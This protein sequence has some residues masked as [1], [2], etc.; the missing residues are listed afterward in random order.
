MKIEHLIAKNGSQTLKINDR[1]VHSFYNPEREAQQ[2]IDKNYHENCIHILFGYGNGHLLEA[3]KER[4]KHDELIVTIDPLLEYLTISANH[5]DDIIESNFED[6]VRVLIEKTKY[7]TTMKFNIIALPL[8]KNLFIEELARITKY[9]F[10][11]QN[12][13]RVNLVT[14]VQRGADWQKNLKLNMVRMIKENSVKDLYKYFNYPVILAASGPSL[15]KQIPLLKKV[16]KKAIIISAGSTTKVLLDHGITPDFITSIEGAENNYNHFKDYFFEETIFVH[17]TYSNHKISDHFKKRPYVCIEEINAYLNNIFNDKL[18]SLPIGGTVAH[19]SLSLANYMTTGP[20][21]LIG[22]DLA[23][24]N[25]QSHVDGH[26]RKTK[27]VDVNE[28]RNLIEVDGYYG[29]K[30]TTSPGMYSMKK[31]FERII[32]DL[33]RKNIDKK[34][35]NCTE[36]GAK[37]EGFDQIPFKVFC[38]TYLDQKKEKTIQNLPQ[39]TYSSLEYRNVKKS[40]EDELKDSKKII[41]LCKDAVTQIKLNKS[42]MFFEQKILRNL[43]KIDKK[44]KETMG[45]ITLKPIIDPIKILVEQNF[46]PKE[47]ETPLEEFNRVKEQNLFWYSETINAMEMSIEHLK[48]ALEMLNEEKYEWTNN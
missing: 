5:R 24:T 18:V 35:F 28:N 27:I 33:K 10:D 9:T 2:I 40:L 45:N 4:R 38:E 6:F 14:S 13:Q 43:D 41:R 25:N 37:L 22:Q 31:S 29:E 36:G 20:I 30:V 39:T 8:Y 26:A 12:H 16:E 48:Q 32:S 47:D 42:K 44:L 11:L 46:Y 23:Y 7:S 15:L 1:F 17:T 19:L 21:A 34:I 3:L